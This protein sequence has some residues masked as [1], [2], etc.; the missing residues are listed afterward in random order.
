M[1]WFHDHL[2]GGIRDLKV[3]GHVEVRDISDN[4]Y[5]YSLSGLTPEKFWKNLPPPIYQTMA[6]N[7]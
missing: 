3:E 7:S 5:G 2:P 4:I 6:L 1:R